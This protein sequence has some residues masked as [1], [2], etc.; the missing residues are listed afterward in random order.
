MKQKIQI[1]KKQ[2]VENENL[3]EGKIIR[4]LSEDLKGEMKIY[5][6]LAKV[7]GISWSFSNAVCNVLKI[8][9]NRTVE[10]LT[11]EEIDKIS[12]FVKNPNVPEFLVN[13][14][15]DFKTGEKKHLIGADLELQTG[16]DIKRLKQIK[17]YKGYRHA[18]KLP[19]RGQRT[20]SHFRKNKLKGVGI[21][22]KQK[23]KVQ[24]PAVY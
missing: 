17:S 11:K 19:L 9:K 23:M 13:R 12:K 15:R 7:K 8:D 16:F 18:A 2:N 24:K 21:K 6:A 5:P 14:R 1:E 3:G 4:I 20:K 10:S 22:K